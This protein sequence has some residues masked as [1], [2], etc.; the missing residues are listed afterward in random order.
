MIIE[1]TNAVDECGQSEQ[2]FFYTKLST[3]PLMEMYLL[4]M[5]EVQFDFKL[6]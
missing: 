1:N 3:S 6:I 5:L 2:L 4:K